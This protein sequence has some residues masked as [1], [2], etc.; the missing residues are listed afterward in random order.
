[1]SD[2][3]N[4]LKDVDGYSEKEIDRFDKIYKV[5]KSVLKFLRRFREEETVEDVDGT[6]VLDLK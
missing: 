3:I 1:M 2:T 5:D 6:D 4:I